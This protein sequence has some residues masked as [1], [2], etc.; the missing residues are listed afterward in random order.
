MPSQREYVVTPS[1]DGHDYTLKVT[2]LGDAK[3]EVAEMRYSFW[4]DQTALMEHVEGYGM[5]QGSRVGYFLFLIFAKHARSAGRTHIAIGTGVDEASTTRNLAA[6]RRDLAAATEAKIDE[7]A[8][9]AAL[10]S[11]NRSMA[12]VKIYQALGFDAADAV[13]L[14][15]SKVHVGEVIDVCVGK[16]KDQWLEWK[17]K[18]KDKSS[19]FLTTACV[20]ARG[21]PDDCEELTVLRRFRDDH[22]SSLPEG[23]TLIAEYYSLAPAILAEIARR[24]DGERFF[25]SIFATLRAC[26]EAIQRAD[27]ATALDLYTAMVRDLQ[28]ELL[29]APRLPVA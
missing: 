21:L 22:L 17:D 23:N 29:G 27:A 4:S 1:T 14:S 11:A 13:R 12:A 26:V 10:E 24:E 8:A 7:T 28:R 9:K 2:A 15:N 3:D 5:P 25:E 20:R 16:V 19:C 18:S 6:A